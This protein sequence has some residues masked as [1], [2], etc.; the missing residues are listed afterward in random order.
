MVGTWCDE[1]SGQ[2][3]NTFPLTANSVRWL[4]VV[5]GVVGVTHV[6]VEFD[7]LSVYLYPDVLKIPVATCSLP[8]LLI[9]RSQTLV[10]I[11][12]GVMSVQVVPPFVDLKSPV[13]RVPRYTFP[14]ASQTIRVP[15][16]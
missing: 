7:G 2:A 8:V 9:S 16:I 3:Y 13:F 12:E 6:G 4:N 14:A 5:K 15:F 10:P 11:P 1:L